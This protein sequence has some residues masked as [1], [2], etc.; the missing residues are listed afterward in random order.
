MNRAFGSAQQL[1]PRFTAH[2]TAR[3]GLSIAVPED[4]RS[5]LF[6]PQLTEQLQMRTLSTKN[7]PSPPV[8]FPKAKRTELKTTRKFR[9]ENQ[10]DNEIDFLRL[11]IVNSKIEAISLSKT[12]RKLEKL[13]QKLYNCVE[14][15]ES[16]AEVAWYIHSIQNELNCTKKQK[17]HRRASLPKRLR[18]SS[19]SKPVNRKAEPSPVEAQL[20]QLK[21]R[22][23]SLL[24][25][26]SR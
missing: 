3:S 10:G 4:L 16:K 22:V 18:K 14:R 11:A 7:S 15:G 8:A 2:K 6:S 5:P 19:S 17:P 21:G 24:S 12:I 13:F 9:K 25:N 26:F 1:V 23:A 20:T